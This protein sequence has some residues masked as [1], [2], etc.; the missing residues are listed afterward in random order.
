MLIH[1]GEFNWNPCDPK[2]KIE[3]KLHHWSCKHF[4]KKTKLCTIYD[5]RPSCCV[6]YPGNG[7]C[8]FPGCE[9]PGNKK[10]LKELHSRAKKHRVA[11]EDKCEKVER[12]SKEYL[13][14]PQ[15]K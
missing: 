14:G 1:L 4:D 7:P 11:G 2:T 6:N 10:R 5:I 9:I 15:R 12:P 8:L 13:S 3:C